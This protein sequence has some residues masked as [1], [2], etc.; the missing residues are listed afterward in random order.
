MKTPCL[1]R[2]HRDAAAAREY[3]RVVLVA[4]AGLWGGVATVAAGLLPPCCLLIAAI[5]LSR[6]MTPY[7]EYYHTPLARVPLWIRLTPVLLSPLMGGLKEQRAQHFAHHRYLDDPQRDPDYAIIHG[8][9]LGAVL[10]CF[11]Q[12][13]GALWYALRRGRVT[14]ECAAEALLRAALLAAVAWLL[15][16]RL[17]WYWLPARLLWTANYL[18]FSRLL[19]QEPLRLPWLGVH[20]YV[21]L[22]LGRRFLPVFLEHQAHHR[23]ARVRPEHLHRVPR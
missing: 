16:P 14:W 15:G 4:Y 21:P 5:L 13:E 7:H 11:L 19:H 9:L 1:Q 10:R 3:A 12:P 8:P 2:Y 22:L 20:L 17:L 6:A 23:D 18:A